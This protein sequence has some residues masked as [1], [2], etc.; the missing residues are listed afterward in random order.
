M[1]PDVQMK[2][3]VDGKDACFQDPAGGRRRAALD[4]P[5]SARIPDPD[6]EASTPESRV[7]VRFRLSSCMLARCSTCMQQPSKYEYST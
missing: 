1:M 7:L 6:S 3:K 2:A 5:A 4:S